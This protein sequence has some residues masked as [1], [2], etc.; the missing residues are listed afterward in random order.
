[1]NSLHP[2]G[3]F[4]CPGIPS[5]NSLDPDQAQ[6]NVGLDQRSKLFDNLI[7]FLQNEAENIMCLNSFITH[8]L[9]SMQRV[10]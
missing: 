6:H 3:G 9:P 8:K 4:I 7:I 2:S 10:M 5:A 1:M